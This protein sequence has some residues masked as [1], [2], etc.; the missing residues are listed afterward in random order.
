M[1][2]SGSPDPIGITPAGP[3]DARRR[4]SLALLL[5]LLIA[6]LL[7]LYIGTNVIGVL[8]GII[9]PPG[10]PAL[11]GQNERSYTSTAYGVDSW[12]YAVD[13]PA[14]SVAE[15]YT[16]YGVCRYA[17]LQCGPL[18]ETPNPGTERWA[19]A[20]CSGEQS[21]SIFVMQWRATVFSMSDNTAEIDLDREIFWIGTGR[22]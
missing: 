19:V 14:C 15:E 3:G 6:V 7:A 12:L 22:E 10:P 13:R 4:P 11:Q 8:F 16:A 9:A 18:S 17:P 1:N 20:R 2:S 5:I 21:F